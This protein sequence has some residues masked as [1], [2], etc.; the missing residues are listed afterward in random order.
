MRPLTFASVSLTTLIAAGAA[1]AQGPARCADIVDPTAR[2]V[3]YDRLDAGRSVRPAPQPV[4][5]AAAPAPVYTPA[6][7]GKD[8]VPVPPEDR[9]FDP[10]AQRTPPEHIGLVEA[11]L[12]QVGSVPVTAMPG[13][14]VPLISLEAPF[15]RPIPGQRWELALL[16]TNN[17][18]RVLDI[19]VTCVFRNGDR[20]VADVEA[21]MRGVRSGDR[22][23]TELPGPQ[24]TTFVDNATCQVRSPL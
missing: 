1:L 13:T 22:V 9:A 23:A 20:P 16:T 15:L 21:L 18:P 3:C 7:V 14:A 12:R 4:T 6:T 19:Q 2:L 24:I 5:R 17:S 10:T 11:S 8:G